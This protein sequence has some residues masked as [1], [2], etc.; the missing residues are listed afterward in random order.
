MQQVE[1]LCKLLFQNVFKPTASNPLA[2]SDFYR[3]KK[4]NEVKEKPKR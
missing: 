2:L 3:P 4:E 1:P